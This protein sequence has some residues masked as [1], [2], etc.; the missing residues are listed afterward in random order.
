MGNFLRKPGREGGSKGTNEKIRSA[1]SC[2]G[3]R[4]RIIGKPR[5]GKNSKIG[6]YWQRKQ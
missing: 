3:Y 2:G 4:V 1:R 5:E 6:R